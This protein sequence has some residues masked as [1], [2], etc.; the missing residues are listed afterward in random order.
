MSDRELAHYCLV[1]TGASKI[2]VAIV[3]S[4]KR[5]NICNPFVQ[6]VPIT[7]SNTKMC[8]FYT[9]TK[10]FRKYFSTTVNIQ[11][12]KTIK[13]NDE[14]TFKEFGGDINNIMKEEK[15]VDF[16]LISNLQ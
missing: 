12:I 14:E 7:H 6:C 1:I 13:P 5:F 4:Y 16:I 15:N 3:F 2:F 9:I 8:I 11:L 10:L